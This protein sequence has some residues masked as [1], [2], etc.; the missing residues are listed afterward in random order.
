ME[1]KK[2]AAA[3]GAC[4][5]NIKSGCI[6]YQERGFDEVQVDSESIDLNT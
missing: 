6:T 5:S 2:G 3:W 4:N 1:A